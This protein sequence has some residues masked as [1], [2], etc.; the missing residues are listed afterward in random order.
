MERLGQWSGCYTR[1]DGSYVLTHLPLRPLALT[2]IHDDFVVLV[3]K[4]DPPEPGAVRRDVRLPRLPALQGRL[5]DSNGHGLAGWS[6]SAE[7]DSGDG[8]GDSA[9]TG[10]DGRFELLYLPASVVQVTVIPPDGDWDHPAL[11]QHGLVA[12]AAPVELRVA[13]E[14]LPTATL[15]GRLVTARGVPIVG[16]ELIA[17]HPWRS[18]WTSPTTRTAEDGSFRFERLCAGD[19]GLVEGPASYDAEPV[20]GLTLVPG[21]HRDVGDVVMDDMP[22]LRVHFTCLDGSR[23]DAPP[24]ELAVYEAAGRGV[25]VAW[26][27]EDGTSEAAVPPGRYRLEV[28]GHDVM[29]MSREVVVTDAGEPTTLELALELGATRDLAFNGDGEDAVSAH[30]TLAVQAHDESGRMVFEDAAVRPWQILVRDNFYWQLSVTLRPGRYH[31]TAHAESGVEYGSWFEV[32][33]QRGGASHIDV[34]RVG[35]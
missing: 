34:P 5:V 4:L 14:A 25:D 21:E 1:P 23:W 3:E 7:P 10:P 29:P 15:A 26:R 19:V 33:P 35:K 28:R 30:T 6:L 17:R 20:T 32:G 12:D 24:P 11:Q 22:T 18:A 9:R 27:T 8:P 31:V 13:A 2:M 16:R